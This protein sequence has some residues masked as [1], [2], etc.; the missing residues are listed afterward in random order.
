[1]NKTYSEKNIRNKK[2]EER[3]NDSRYEDRY[4][5]E[6]YQRKGDSGPSLVKKRSDYGKQFGK[7]YY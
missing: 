3:Y 6:S 5:N 4:K 7:K 2:E 1:L